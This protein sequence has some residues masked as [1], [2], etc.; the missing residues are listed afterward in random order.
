MRTVGFCALLL[1]TS[2]QAANAETAYVTDILRLGL[3]AAQD[4]S[5]RPFRTLVSGAELEVLQRVPN[6][7]EVRTEDGRQGWVK[8]AYLVTDKPAQLIVSET[9]A[10]LEKAQQDLVTEQQGRVA[11]ESQ[12]HQLLNDAESKLGQV[13]SMEARLKQLSARNLELEAQLDTYRSVVPLT[14]AA[15][16]VV[17]S[18]L[19]GFFL[20]LW[21]LDAYIRHRHGGF[22]VY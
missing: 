2:L 16:A 12:L 5:D 11:A 18:L 3:H 1:I 14:W 13:V 9:Q 15:S 22:R 7:A 17:A 21:A 19:G 6:F 8:S 10:A 20:G 4:T